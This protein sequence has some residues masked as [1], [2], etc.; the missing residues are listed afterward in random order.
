MG[1]LDSVMNAAVGAMS[2]EQGNGGV[3]DVAASLIKDNP[4]G[5]SGLVSKLQEGGL[6]EA[7]NSWV[8]TGDNMAVSADAIAGALG[9]GQLAELAGKFG[10]SQEQISSG[11]ATV[12]PEVIN[13]LT[14]NGAVDGQS[15]AL[16]EAG[17]N[18]L[19]SKL[20]G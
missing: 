7:V 2:G 14:P 9:Q 13:H 1:L 17:L 5:L 10:I 20:F 11:L 8:G 6:A 12:L 3:M 4:D 18:L 15:N 16:L 19:K